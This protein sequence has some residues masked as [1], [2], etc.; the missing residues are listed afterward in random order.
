[1]LI[2]KTNK[3]YC[4]SPP[5]MLA[6]FIIEIAFALYVIARYK[7]TPISRLAVAILVGL[8]VFQLAEYNICETAWGMDSLSWARIGY[9]AITFLPP[10]GFHL[11]TRIAGQKQPVLVAGAYVAAIA[12]AAFFLFSG[13]GMTGQQCLGNYVIFSIAPWATKLYAVYYY[14]LLA[15]SVAYSWKASRAVK[16]KSK[17]QALIALAVGYL[18]FIVPTTAANIIDPS[19][20]SGIPSIMCG[21]AVIL[22]IVLT[23]V[24]VPKAHKK[25]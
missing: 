2:L 19:T 8:A 9:V 20:I 1:M 25:V 14:G 12:F 13:Q 10:L 5:I 16:S 4:F 24:V 15:L 7:L 18:G 11:A 21:F 3:L 22:A 23:L 6:T 17:K